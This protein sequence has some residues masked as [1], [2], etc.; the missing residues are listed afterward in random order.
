M[1]L[2]ALL[3]LVV[4]A[5]L[6][7]CIALATR[8]TDERVEAL[9]LGTTGGLVAFST[10]SFFASVWFSLSTGLLWLMVAAA[11]ALGLVV[12]LR[13]SVLDR[14][15]ELVLDRTALGLLIMFAPLS[16][17]IS[18]KLLFQDGTELLTGVLN[19][20]GDLGWHFSVITLLGAQPAFPP[21]DPI[22][23]GTP[24]IYPFM[25]DFQSS[26]LLAAG[27]SYEKSV[28]APAIVLVPTFFVLFFRLSRRLTG[29]AG[30][31]TIAVL[32]LFFGGST[33]G[34]M[35]LGPD[36]EESG[37]SLWEFATNL[38]R[39]YTGKGHDPN[40]L[41]FLNIITSSLLPQRSFLFGMPLAVS[42]LLLL[43]PQGE[44]PQPSRFGAAGVLAGLM[45][46]SHAHTVVALT[47]VIL[48]LAA[49]D[50][51][52]QRR[53][54][55][56]AI[57]RWAVFGVTA[58][59]VGCPQIAYYF[60]SD[61]TGAM[62]PRWDPGWTL[63]EHEPFRFWVQNTGALLLLSILGL[64]R[65]T[66]TNARLFSLAGLAL[67]AL[68]NLFLLAPWP[69]D[70][71][72]LLIFWLILSLPAIASLLGRVL[73]SKRW[74]ARG[75]AALLIAIHMLSGALDLW[76][77]ALPSNPSWG[78]W[79]PAAVEFADSIRE[80][81][82]PGSTILTAP[83]HNSPVALA[84]RPIYLGFPPHVWGHGKAFSAREQSLQGFYEGDVEELAEEQVDYVVVGPVERS[85]FEVVVRRDWEPVA[86][87]ADYALYRMPRESRERR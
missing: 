67:F 52:V 29:A 18:S 61:T 31:A 83:Y 45:P 59:V 50:L 78:E 70:N 9:L 33:L 6:G 21:E 66:P 12:A 14:W 81:T 87:V 56:P 28:V 36:L 82:E 79:S 42:I 30:P 22:L 40:G 76:R 32:L 72:K 57:Q 80:V 7:C 17:V 23:A 51:A 68:G 2:L 24:L 41:H 64:S 85:R 27:A 74:I 8:L 71:F 26:T 60:Q 15:R 34:W 39:E 62:L 1:T 35:Q 63:G 25:A 16:I 19:A 86:E 53:E 65:P 77:L 10:A 75:A 37:L 44:G 84:G 13:H 54:L 47:P 73:S 58:L 11:V 38:P 46:L 4:P 55:R 43:L 3:L 69:W 48:L 20:W 49:R 5:A